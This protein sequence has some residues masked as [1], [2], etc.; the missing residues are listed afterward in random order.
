ML[1]ISFN[2]LRGVRF[3]Y[4]KM[5]QGRLHPKLEAP[6]SETSTNSQNSDYP[7]KVV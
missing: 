1:R 3:F 6:K 5:G 4:A 7:N 2:G